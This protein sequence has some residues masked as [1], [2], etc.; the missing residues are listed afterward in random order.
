LSLSSYKVWKSFV[1]VQEAIAR[2]PWNALGRRRRAS[3]HPAAGF[4]V[5]DEVKTI[6]AAIMKRQSVVLIIAGAICAALALPASAGNLLTNGDFEDFTGPFINNPPDASGA[7]GP[8]TTNS[9]TWNRWLVWERFQ[10]VDSTTLVDPT[11]GPTP[12]PLGWGGDNFAQHSQALNP[13]SGTGDQTDQIK[14]GVDG[15]RIVPGVPVNL[16][17][18]YINTEPGRLVRVTVYGIDGVQVWSQFASFPCQYPQFGSAEQTCT[19]LYEANLASSAEGWRNFEGSFTPATSHAV[20]AIGISIGG[21]SGYA[22]GVDDVVLSQAIEVP[23]DVLPTSCPNPFNVGATGV[24]PVAILGTADFDV[25]DIDPETVTLEGVSP[26]RSSLEDT[27]TPYQPFVGKP[28]D[29]YACELFGPDG[30]MDLV[31]HFDRQA[32]AAA[33]GSVA[34]GDVV[35]LG[36]EGE[37]FDGTP[38]VGEDV[39]RIIKR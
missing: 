25:T 24:L 21:N 28:L 6:G 29:Q 33:I 18:K 3:Q 1:E 31:L 39:V 16:S 14:Q 2:T 26:L 7:N 35:M 36:L 32:I 37:L 19:L 15:T 4:P 27:A 13:A 22:R 10:S 8:I 11:L 17:F 34:N 5:S 23:V 30:Y 38:I 12:F 9:A 20:V